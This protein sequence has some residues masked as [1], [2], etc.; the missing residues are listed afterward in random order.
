MT[1]KYLQYIRD[2]NY[3][4]K[5]VGRL[6]VSKC[7]GTID[8]EV[9]TRN[10][11][12]IVFI[13]NENPV[14]MLNETGPYLVQYAELIHN[15]QWDTFMNMEYKDIDDTPSGKTQIDILKKTFKLCTEKEKK[16]ISTSVSEMLSIY[17]KYII[18]VKSE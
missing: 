18:K 10:L 5:Y 1:D 9:S 16:I 4:L 8:E 14:F 15:N 11:R 13:I 7:K 12:R 17:C 3:Q 2:Y 6:Y